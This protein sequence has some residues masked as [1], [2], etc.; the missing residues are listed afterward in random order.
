M[1][2]IVVIGSLQFGLERLTNELGSGGDCFR[3]FHTVYSKQK[4]V[5]KL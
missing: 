3:V 1:D 2:A 5:N 4:S